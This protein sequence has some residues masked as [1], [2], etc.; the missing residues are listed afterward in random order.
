MRN[1]ISFFILSRSGSPVK[2]IT[3]SKSF[4]RFLFLVVFAVLS[5][6]IVG[7]YDYLHLRKSAAD[8]QS[9]QETIA[10]QHAE[11]I[12]QRKQIEKFAEEIN[13]LKNRLAALGDFERKIRII[14]NLENSEEQEGLFGMGGPLPE[15]LDT[16]IPL[17]ERHHSL[18][19]EMHQQTHG[20]V[21]ATAHQENQFKSLIENLQGQVNLLASTPAIRPNDGWLTCGFG[22]RKS[23]FTGLKEF[24]KGIDIANRKGTPIVATADGVV[25]VAGRK[26]LLGKTIEIDHGH[27]I[28]TR[29]GHAQKL[30]KKRGDKIKRGET[31]A[32][33][34]N[35]GR[36]TGSHVHYEVLL[37]GIPVNPKKYILN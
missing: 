27:G 2:Q 13:G 22:Y 20:L 11:I 4:L 12:G 15:D 9:F 25:T 18:M 23:P 24:H 33:I 14:A 3:A 6:S 35:T 29:Y 26:G 30:L 34:G 17:K 36:T 5:L 21:L 32:L 28:I 1:K 8:T 10:S 16:R 7:L 37:N 31:I 19:R